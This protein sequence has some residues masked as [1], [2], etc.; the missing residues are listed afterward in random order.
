MVQDNGTSDPADQ[1]GTISF[2]EALAQ[3]TA[4]VESLEKGELPLEDALRIYEKGAELTRLCERQLQDAELRV[5]RW[6]DGTEEAL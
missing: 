4:V 3:L 6:Q 2:E 5:T 1:E